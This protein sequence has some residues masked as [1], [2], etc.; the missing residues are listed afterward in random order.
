MTIRYLP[1]T[2]YVSMPWKNGTGST[3][4][5]CLLPPD[6]SRD[7]FELRVSRAII[8]TSGLFSAFPGVERTIT[9]IEGEGLALEFDDHDVDLTT[10]QP[11]RFDSGLTPVG[12]PKGGTVRVVNVMAARDAWHLAPAE[13]L[14]AGT[15]VQPEPHGLTIV[16]ALRGASEL[17]DSQA[18]VTLGQEDCALLDAP[19]RFVPENGSALLVVPLRRA[20]GA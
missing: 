2:G 4:E 14:T 3:D 5:I 9:V 20:S 18:T 12:V 8:A 13:I 1:A 15:L 19:A 11:H 16:F 10:G 6:A 17:S 7:A